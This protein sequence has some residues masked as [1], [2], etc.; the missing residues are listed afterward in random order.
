MTAAQYVAVIVLAWVVLIAG[1]VA[2][3]RGAKWL[4]KTVEEEM[5]AIAPAPWCSDRKGERE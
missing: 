2:F 1:I 3:F 5:N 4:D